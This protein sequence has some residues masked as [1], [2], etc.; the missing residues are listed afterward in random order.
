[1]PVLVGIR[2]NPWLRTYYLRLRAAGKRPKVAIIAAMHKLL[3]AIYSVAKHRTP[4]VLQLP[5]T[6]T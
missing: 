2:L 1:M 3:I 5:A 6:L 4:F